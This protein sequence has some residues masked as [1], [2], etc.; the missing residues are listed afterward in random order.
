MFAMEQAGGPDASKSSKVGS[1]KV[2]ACLSSLVTACM[3]LLLQHA[4][5]ADGLLSCSSP[6]KARSTKRRNSEACLQPGALDNRAL[7]RG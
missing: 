7:R 5:H 4:A 6:V 2:P 1:A 3:Q